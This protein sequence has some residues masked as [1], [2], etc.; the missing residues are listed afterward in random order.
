MA[1][2]VSSVSEYISDGMKIRVGTLDKKSPSTIYVTMS[3]YITPTVV[4]K[5][6]VKRAKDMTDNFKRHAGETVR[7]GVTFHGDHI[8]IDEIPAGSMEYG[9][10]TYIELQAYF[11]TRP[12]ILK[13]YDGGFKA[14]VDSIMDGDLG[15]FIKNIA[16]DIEKAGFESREY[17]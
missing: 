6:Y 14:F 15:K 13:S 17:R 7:E 3:M 9:K 5:S 11:R 4:E 1:R 12:N 2:K 16:M 8:F 10:R